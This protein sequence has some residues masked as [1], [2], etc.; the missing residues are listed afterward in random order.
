MPSPA[1]N[2]SADP[3]QRLTTWYRGCRRAGRG[4]GLHLQSSAGFVPAHWVFLCFSCT[5]WRASIQVGLG[6]SLKIF[7]SELTRARRGWPRR[8]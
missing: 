5:L 8:S 3:T 1:T 2:H 7:T 4:C 6:N